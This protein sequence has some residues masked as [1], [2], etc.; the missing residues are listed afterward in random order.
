MQ[1]EGK[2]IIYNENSKILNRFFE[3]ELFTSPSL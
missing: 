2:G 1:K 3:K